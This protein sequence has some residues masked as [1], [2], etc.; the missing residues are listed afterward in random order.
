MF[1][2]TKSREL[3]EEQR[4]DADVNKRHYSEDVKIHRWYYWM[5]MTVV[6]TVTLLNN[7]NNNNNNNYNNNNNDKKK[8][9]WIRDNVPMKN[10]GMW[11]RSVLPTQKKYGISL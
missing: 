3:D 10:A 2:M 8:K 5:V 1:S 7:N 4:Q 9:S 11:W 6:Q